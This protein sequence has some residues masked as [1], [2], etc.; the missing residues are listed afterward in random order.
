MGVE[1]KSMWRAKIYCEKSSK[2]VNTLP[3]SMQGILI[4]KPLKNRMKNDIKHITKILI[5]NPFVLCKAIL[6]Q[7]DNHI[8]FFQVDERGPFNTI[9][10][11]IHI[12]IKYNSI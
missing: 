5:I 8:R 12:K 10:V 9:K 11:I 3:M 7:S 4:K 2:N 1:S 6:V